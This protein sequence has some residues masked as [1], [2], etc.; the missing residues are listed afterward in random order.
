MRTST[1][2]QKQRGGALA[3]ER[4][5]GLTFA[6]IALVPVFLFVVLPIIGAFV[7]SFTSVTFSL[8]TVPWVGLSNYKEVLGDPVTV[9]ATINTVLFAVAVAILTVLFAFPTALLMD[10]GVKIVAA[11]R[12]VCV[13]PS[14]T[15]LVA[16][17]V[18][19]LVMFDPS[20]PVGAFQDFFGLPP[21]NL[22][23]NESTALLSLAFITAWRIFGIFTLIYLA[24]LQSAP[25]IYYEA[26]RIDGAGSFTMIR[27]IT[28]PMVKPVTYYVIVIAMIQGL[29][30]FDL[31]LVMTRGGPMDSTQSLVYQAYTNA[32]VYNRLGYGSSIAFILFVLILGV[33]LATSRLVK[34]EAVEH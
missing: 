20:G 21:V 9:R 3:R 27:H 8:D 17:G 13:I 33:T 15:P 19:W 29:Q 5:A 12:I 16:I 14:V 24:A 10:S 18:I 7:L 23:R 32:F 31:I 34:H 4:R 25:Q 2:Q 6:C 28:W 26:A 22:I 1:S 11:S 30:A